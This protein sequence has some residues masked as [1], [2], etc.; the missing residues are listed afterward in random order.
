MAGKACSA[1]A[2]RAW[3][4]RHGIKAVIPVREDQKNIAVTVGRPAA[5]RRS[6]IR[7][8]TTSATPSSDASA[9]SSS[10]GPWPP[11]ATSERIYQ[12]TIDVVSISIWV[13]DPVP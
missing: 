10:S 9:S 6:S 13:R 3:L 11:A 8:G 1:A 4:R 12:A 7:A 5:G 2:N